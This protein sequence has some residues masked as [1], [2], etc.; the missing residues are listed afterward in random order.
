MRNARDDVHV[1]RSHRE[2]AS[3]IGELGVPHEVE[4]R[5]SDDYFSA[6][7]YIPGAGVALEVDGPTH[8]INIAASGEGGAPGDASRTPTRTV[9]TE[10][11]DMFLEKRHEAVVIVPYFEW[12][13]LRGSDEKK[14]YVSEKLRGAG[15]H[16][17]S[18]A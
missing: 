7:V 2:M 18:S 13:V 17:P 10:L 3:I 15:V 1:S 14:R 12:D 5:T 8:F 4:R 11:R 6:D 16:V 9:R